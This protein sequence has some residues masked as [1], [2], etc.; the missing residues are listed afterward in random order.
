[1]IVDDEGPGIPADR[2]Q[3]VFERFYQIDRDVDLDLGGTG[4][5]LAIAHWAVMA[6]HGRIAIDDSPAGGT[7]VVVA[8]PRAS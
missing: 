3:H 8:M 7:R 1:L 4:L 2:R 5:G 6:H